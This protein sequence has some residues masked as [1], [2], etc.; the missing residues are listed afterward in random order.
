MLSNTAAWITRPKSTPLEVKEAPYPT[1]GATDIVVETAAV[2]INPLEY[3]IQDFN[4]AIGGKALNYP[5]VLGSDLAGTV[6]SVGS[7]VMNCKTGDRVLAHAP[8][9]AMGMPERSAFQK[10][11]LLKGN[12]VTSIPRNISFEEAVVLPLACDTAMAGLFVPRALGLSTDSLEGGQAVSSRD[13]EVLLIWGGSSSVGCC[14]IQMSRAAGYDVYVTA[15]AKNYE[16]CKSLGATEVFDYSKHDVEASIVAALQ[17]KKVAGALDC[18]ADGHSTVP[19]CTRILAQAVG[20]KKVIT[21]LSPPS[22]GL[23]AAVEA[24]RR[25]Y[26]A[27][28]SS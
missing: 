6:I 22:S 4:P 24:Q 11:V 19:A 26:A 3:K 28:N 23:D 5:T 18:I 10:Y 20:K 8:G 1:P 2:A 14:A 13:H 12:M 9:S 17:G 21:V 15:S 7:D 25:E 16:L 27:L